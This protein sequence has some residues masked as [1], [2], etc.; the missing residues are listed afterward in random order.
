M[1]DQVNSKIS[2]LAVM[3]SFRVSGPAKQLLRSTISGVASGVTTTLALFQR[4]AE[5]SPFVVSARRAQVP[6]LVIRDRFAGD[7]G[8]VVALAKHIRD[9][10]PDIL[11]THGYKANI[12][13]R[14]LAPRF[15]LPWIAFLHGETWENWKVR[16]Y[17]ALER[18]A[19]CGADRVVAVSHEMVTRLVARGIP[20][21]KV[22]A[23]HNACLFEPV[24][25]AIHTASCH[26]TPPVV[27]VVARLSPEKGVDVGLHVHALVTRRFPD[28]RL[29]IAGEGPEANTLRGLA[30][31]LGIAPAVQ[32]LGY[33]EDVSDLY[34]HMAI[35]LI[36]SRSEG[37]PN[38]ALEAMAH[39]LPVVAAAV[40][41]IPEVITDGQSGFL[42]PPG[43]VETLALRV[44]QLLGDVN[45][46]QRLG[47]RG[48]EEVTA[49]FSPAM[50]IRALTAIYEEVLG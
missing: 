7:L 15:G 30:E 40:G 25:D 17:S 9:A 33:R 11:Q 13:G 27:G 3:D 31:R 20:S 43:D 50:R 19:I 22:R 28:A 32:W 41:G 47:D 42:A 16:V 34:R 48:R 49:R 24:S 44:G 23:V 36:P 4:S 8:I 12:V 35:L 5:P 2:V 45:L 38:V 29:F 14:L 46:R 10:K 18:C 39:G 21:S 6:V 1:I 26:D 37:L